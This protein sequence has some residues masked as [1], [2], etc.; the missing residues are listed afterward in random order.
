M[1]ATASTTVPATIEAQSRNKTV[2]KVLLVCGV[3]ASLL[4]FGTDLIAGALYPGYSFTSQAIS[5]LFAIGAPTG[6]L[7]VPLFTV[8]D[9]LLLAFARGV[10]VSAVRN[11][12]LRVTALMLVGNAVNGLVL[13]NVFPMHMRGV[14]ATFT[15]TMHVDLSGVGVVFVLLGIV[16]GAAAFGNWFRPYSIATV[17]ILLLPAMVV[18]FLYVPQIEANLPTPWTGLAERI[19]AYGCLLWQ[20]ILAIVLLRAEGA[21]RRATIGGR[22]G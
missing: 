1:T 3:I 8:Y 14:E 10:W 11:R 5:E 20:A 21:S 18:F 22:L 12:A 6:W 13:W 7:V 15:D 16:S 19:S 2:K 9:V 4:S 17:L